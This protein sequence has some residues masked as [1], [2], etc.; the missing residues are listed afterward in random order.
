LASIVDKQHVQ[1]DYAN[2]W[3]APAIAY[4]ILLQRLQQEIDGKATIIIDDMMGATPFGNT[5]KDNLIAHHQSLRK[6]G[7]RLLNGFKYSCLTPK[8]KFVD[9]S[10]SHLI[11]VADI[12]AYNVH[13]QF[14]E[15]G[16]EWESET[17]DE[18]PTYNYF[19][20]ILGKFRK[21][22]RGRIQGY[23]VVKFPLRNRVL[24][25]I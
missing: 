1:E 13:R 5:Y 9:S 6:Y 2:P 12:A 19:Q 25:S 24:W 21:G 18:L 20:A 4:E 7:S 22:P 14:R 11:Q 16:E 15:F 23:G 3:H 8:L 10:A 17:L